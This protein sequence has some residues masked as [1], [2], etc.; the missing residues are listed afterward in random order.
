M[1]PGT[2]RIPRAV[3][4][5]QMLDAAVEIFAARG[6]RAASMDA[7][8]AEAKISKPMLYLYYGSKDELFSAVV[9]RESERL[10]SAM[11]AGWD[12]HLKQS[13]QVHIIIRNILTYVHGHQDSWRVI[14]R[15]SMAHPHFAELV[16][17][18]RSRLTELLSEV[19]RRGLQKP[20]RDS[21]IEIMSITIVGALEAISD[22]ISEGDIDIDE[23]ATVLVGM[24]WR[25]LSGDKNEMA[26]KN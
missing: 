11:S 14:Y 21:E 25:G 24:G 4:E 6:Y 23:A 5:Q 20:L 2:K 22:R 19:L 7:I 16:S 1:A 12:P 18:S 9:V 3:R 26:T 15:V 8:A 13:E 10:V 17:I